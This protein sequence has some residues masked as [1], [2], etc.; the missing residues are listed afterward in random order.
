MDIQAHNPYCKLVGEWISLDNKLV[1]LVYAVGNDGTN[2]GLEAYF[3]RYGLSK[4]HYRSYRW[5][6]GKIPQKYTEHYEKLKSYVNEVPEGHK[7]T[8]H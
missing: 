2:E 4:P 8:I 1:E 6:D 3:Y 5:L 7:L